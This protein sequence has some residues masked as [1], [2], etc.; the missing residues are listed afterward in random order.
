M[1]GAVQYPEQPEEVEQILGSELQERAELIGRL[2]RYYRGEHRKP[3]KVRPGQPDD[4][5]ILNLARHV[6]D[7]S[8]SLLFGDPPEIQLEEG[9]LTPAEEALYTILQANRWDIWLHDLG[10]TGAVAG[11][12]FVRLVP[13]EMEAPPRL[14]V[15]D[16][17]KVAVFWQADDMDSVLFYALHWTDAEGNAVRQDIVRDGQT[18]ALREWVHRG[19]RWE[20]R[21]EDVWPHP[22]PPILDWKNLPRP[23]EYYGE[24]DI[25]HAD[26]NDMVNFVASNT[27]RILRYHAH[28][29]TIGTGVQ[30]QQVHETAVDGFWAIP[31]PEAKIFNLEMQSD[32]RSS[33]EFLGLLRSAFFAVSR[34]VDLSVYADRLGQITNFGLRILFHDALA[35]CRTKQVLYGAALEELVR[36]LLD[37]SGYGYDHDVAIH[38]KDPLPF[39]DLEQ[40]QVLEKELELGILSRETAAALRG[41]DWETEQTRMAAERASE[42][43]IGAELLRAF[44]RGEE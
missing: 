12:C 20:L 1:P 43:N 22:W 14:V 5:I 42:T 40:V 36:R 11:H 32:L 25:I 18:W 19:M 24:S 28:P 29:K 13:G 39:S 34:A 16:P 8:V 15:L 41:R 27:N 23:G 10:V 26:I 7:Q 35:K 4:N 17:A 3:L 37:L 33:M 30:P 38:W 44:E 21:A 2:W 9:V 31:S 6:V